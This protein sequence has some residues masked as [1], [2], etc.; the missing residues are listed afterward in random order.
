MWMMNEGS[1]VIK[2]GKKALRQDRAW[3]PKLHIWQISGT[4]YER[5]ACSLD[6][7]AVDFLLKPLSILLDSHCFWENHVEFTGKKEPTYSIE[8]QAASMDKPK[9]SKVMKPSAPAFLHLPCLASSFLPILQLPNKPPPDLA[10]KEPI[11]TVVLKVH[12]HSDCLVALFKYRFL[13]P[14][15][16]LPIQ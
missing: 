9:I 13:S 15:A 7:N 1:V 16:N 4:V 10:A 5:L 14:T 12:L 11:R 3:Q 6:G 8:K 2:K